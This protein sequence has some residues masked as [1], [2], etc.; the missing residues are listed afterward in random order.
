MKRAALALLCVPAMACAQNKSESREL[1][2][3]IGSRTAYMVMQGTQREDGGWHVSGEYVLL[4][5]L[6]RRFVEGDRGPELGAISL[7]EGTTP[8]L[9]GRKPTGELRGV[10]RGGVFKGTRYGP[11][12]QERERFELS[13][14]FPSMQGYSAEVR[15]H[16]ES[17]SLAYAVEGGQLKGFEWRS[18]N[19]TLSGLQQE[20]M[21][22]GLRFASA[23]CAVT[24]RDLGEAV[25]VAATDCRQHCGSEGAMEP[26]LVDRRGNCRALRPEAR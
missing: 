2:G 14:N 19:C 8:I 4:P 6:T 22:G 15:C 3:Q 20:P 17:S 10:W 24:L 1:V 7:K 12:G 9:F 11:G 5:T 21:Q 23:H 25:K 13:E 18:A 16:A 26:V